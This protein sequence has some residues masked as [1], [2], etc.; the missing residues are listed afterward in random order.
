MTTKKLYFIEANAPN[1]KEWRCTKKR[2]DIVCNNKIEKNEPH[3]RFGANKERHCFSCGLN[4]LKFSWIE[5]V[6]LKNT[7]TT[8]I[9]KEEV[10][11]VYASY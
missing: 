10:I 7:K 6:R 2:F 5:L 1:S 11:K 4:L 9:T 8:P 3:F